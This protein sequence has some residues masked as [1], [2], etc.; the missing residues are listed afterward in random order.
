MI[1]AS[2]E[3]FM[4]KFGLDGIRTPGVRNLDSSDE[5]DTIVAIKA[6]VP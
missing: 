6:A 1:W 5:L 4:S 3:P 2:N